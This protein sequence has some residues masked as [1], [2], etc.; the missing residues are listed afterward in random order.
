MGISGWLWISNSLLYIL[1][2][3]TWWAWINCPLTSPLLKAAIIQLTTSIFPLSEGNSNLSLKAFETLP[4]LNF[5]PEN[6]LGRHGWSL[7]QNKDQAVVC[8]EPTSLGM[9]PSCWNSSRSR[10][11]Q[12]LFWGETSSTWSKM[13]AWIHN[14]FRTVR[15]SAVDKHSLQVG[16]FPEECF[17]YKPFK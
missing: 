6:E 17:G 3:K 9:Y 15:N 4:V 11:N 10:F 7:D 1:L 12:L 5:M 16:K 2:I 8:L 14:L 13:E